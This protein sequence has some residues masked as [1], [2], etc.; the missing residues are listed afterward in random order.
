MVHWQRVLPLPI[1]D[2]Q[3]ESVV[4]DLEGEARRLL[5]FCGLDWHPECLEFYHSKRPVFTA[6]NVQV[7]QPVYTS[8]VGRW[9]QYEDQLQPLIDNLPPEAIA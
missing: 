8:S 4:A 2:I 5:D 7:R 1:H 3:Y 6:S 9:R